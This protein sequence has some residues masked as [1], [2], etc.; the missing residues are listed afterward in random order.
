MAQ[1]PRLM[2][3]GAHPDDAEFHAGGLAW[4]YAAAGFPILILCLTD[5]SAG[6]ARLDRAELAAR[7]RIEA[8]RAADLLDAKLEIWDTS[9]GELDANLA[10]RHQLIREIRRFAPDLIVTHRVWDYHPDHRAAGQ[11]VQDACYMV[12]VPNVC[13]D[14]PALAKDPVVAQMCDFFA[15]PVAFSADVTLDIEAD[16]EHVVSLLACHESQVYEWLP[17][18]LGHEGEPD[19]ARL[20]ELFGRRAGAIAKRHLPTARYAEA[21]EISEYGHRPTEAELVWLFPGCRL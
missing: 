12:R 6:H 4:R 1:P 21:F 5:G 15:K 14:T 2:I 3:V 20:R 16:F 9:D 18:M 10:L 13:P 8:S 17:F 11:L 19:R 7:R